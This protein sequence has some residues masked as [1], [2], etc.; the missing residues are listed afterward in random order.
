M[1]LKTHLF[2]PFLIALQFLTTLPVCLPFLPSRGQ[3]ALSLLYYP[4]IGLMIGGVLWLMASYIL[5][6]VMLLSIMIVAVWVW[7]TGGLH[8]DGL[9]DTADA[10]VGGYGDRERTLAI[11]KDPN[12][13]AMG[14]LALVLNIAIK[15]AAVYSLLAFLNTQALLVLIFIPMLGRL[16]P[17]LLFLTTPYVRQNGLGSALGDAK[18]SPLIIVVILAVLSLFC[19]DWQLAIVLVLTLFISV[20]YLRTRFIGRIGGITGDTVGASIELGETAL[21]IVAVSVFYH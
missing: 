21:L 16:S 17:L 3:N 19:L 7:I 2:I 9:A 1:W 5:L 4:V 15:W 14:I 20:F 6:P 10:W 18:K 11:M 13:G 8:L 12:S